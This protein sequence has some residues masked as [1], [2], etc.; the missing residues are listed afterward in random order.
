MTRALILVA[1]GFQDEEF[2]YPYYRMREEGWEVT[3][4][5]RNKNVRGKF[6]VPPRASM[7]ISELIGLVLAPM[8]YD[9]LF[10]PGGFE[11]PDRMREIPV[12]LSIV[13]HMND[14]GKTIGAICHG[15]SVLISAG[16][17]RNRRVTGY[18]AI[19]PDLIN[20][21][22]IVSEMPQ[23]VEVD[24]NLV[25]G[26]HYAANAPFM[27]ALIEVERQRGGWKEQHVSTF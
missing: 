25:T 2:I 20:A 14:E 22:G 7:M 23:A 5:A 24:G 3:V 9:V 18:N 21:G 26:H 4:A 12:V 16:I 8:P 10:I 6:G 1:E 15:P 13:R 17:V 27:K 11:S 19:K